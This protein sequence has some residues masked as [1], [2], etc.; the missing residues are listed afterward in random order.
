P[1]SFYLAVY[2]LICLG[3]VLAVLWRSTLGL[4]RGLVASR[5]LH[6]RLLGSVMRA[7]MQFFDT[8]PLGA[9]PA[10]SLLLLLLL[11]LRRH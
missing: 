1:T 3:S 7:P 5:R 11:L 6:D 8:T 9:R 2:S 10:Q 4:R